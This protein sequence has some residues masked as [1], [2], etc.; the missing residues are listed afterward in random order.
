[1]CGNE[2]YITGARKMG[3]CLDPS[4]GFATGI[5]VDEKELTL[6]LGGGPGVKSYRPGCGRVLRLLG[7]EELSI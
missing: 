5:E 3:F 2:V 6:G 4:F 1:V 7:R